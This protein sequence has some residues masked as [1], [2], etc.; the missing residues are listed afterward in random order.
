[1]ATT[2]GIVKKTSLEDFSHPRKNGIAAITIEEHDG[3]LLDAGSTLQGAYIL[4]FSP[5]GTL[6]WAKGYPIADAVYRALV[7]TDAKN[8]IYLGADIQNNTT[9]API[10]LGN[11][12]T[13][14]V[15]LGSTLLAKFDAN[16]NPL[17]ANVYGNITGIP[18]YAGWPT[19][20]K[21]DPDGN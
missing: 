8:N 5:A 13:P 17:W 16:G 10:T 15:T 18:D 9:P 11:V 19:C 14:Q 4:K 21:T 6:L 1:M 12:T 7:S 3:I 2:N 20:M